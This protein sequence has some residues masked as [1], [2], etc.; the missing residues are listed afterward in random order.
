[1]KNSISSRVSSP[2]SLFLMMISTT[3]I[4]F[5]LL[6]MQSYFIAE[7]NHG[8]THTLKQ[9]SVYIHLRDEIMGSRNIS[10]LPAYI[11]PLNPAP[12]SLARKS[13]RAIYQTQPSPCWR[14]PKRAAQPA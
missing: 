3:R 2:L 13:H 14:A 6:G 5:S 1:M 7:I 12:S 9:N 4:G 10:S 8:D 11:H